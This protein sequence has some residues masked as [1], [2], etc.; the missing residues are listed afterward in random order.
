MTSYLDWKNFLREEGK[1]P[2]I[3]SVVE[4]VIQREIAK[5]V[6]ILRR[7]LAIT[8]FSATRGLAFRGSQGRIGKANNGNFLGS[9]KL[10]SQFDDCLAAHLNEIKQ[11]TSRG[12]PHYL[13]WKIQNELEVVSSKVL[14]ETL[15]ERRKADF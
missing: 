1:Q 12:S 7:L 2:R 13:S 3:D 6:K 9:V 10:L 14:Q 11:G 8:L 4:E 15:D 5:W